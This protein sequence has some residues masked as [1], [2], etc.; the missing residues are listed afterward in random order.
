MCREISIILLVPPLL[1]SLAASDI[2][3]PSGPDWDSYANLNVHGNGHFGNV[4]RLATWALMSELNDDTVPNL[5]R[6]ARR[7]LH[8]IMNSTYHLYE[9]RVREFNSSCDECLFHLSRRCAAYTKA[10]LERR[11]P[12]AVQRAIDVASDDATAIE[13]DA[14]NRESLLE[15]KYIEMALIKL[16][17]MKEHNKSQNMQE[18]DED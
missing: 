13:L 18:A 9:L 12:R 7:R 2:G 17:I 1:P 6:S 14:T 4:L 8:D 3:D 5:N 10:K 15:Q 16:Q 11:N